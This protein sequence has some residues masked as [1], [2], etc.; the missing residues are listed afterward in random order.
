MMD[1]CSQLPAAMQGHVYVCLHFLYNQSLIHF[2]QPVQFLA[3]RR[4]FLLTSASATDSKKFAT[5]HLLH[6]TSSNERL[7]DKGVYCRLCR[8]YYIDA[9]D[10]QWIIALPFSHTRFCPIPN[11]H[12]RAASPLHEPILISTAS[13]PDLDL[14]QRFLPRSSI[15]PCQASHSRAGYSL[16]TFPRCSPLPLQ[17]VFRTAILLATHQL[18]V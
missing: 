7:S 1:L 9:T 11:A 6:R 12:P 13:K 15:R 3:A 2:P 10:I 17:T 4:F 14:N 18:C 16:A 8:L 5:I